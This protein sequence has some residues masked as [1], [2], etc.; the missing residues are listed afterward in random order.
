[1]HTEQP[2]LVRA[3]SVKEEQA[4]AN[5]AYQEADQEW[6][7]SDFRHIFA[8]SAEGFAPIADLER[9]APVEQT[10]L[11]NTRAC[12]KRK[13]DPKDS[14][15]KNAKKAQLE[16]NVAD[17]AAMQDRCAKD[18]LFQLTRDQLHEFLSSVGKKV[19][20][21]K[22]FLIGRI[23][24][25]FADSDGRAHAPAAAVDAV[26]LA[27]ETVSFGGAEHV[28]AYIIASI[29]KKKGTEKHHFPY[30]LPS[31]IFVLEDASFFGC[32]LLCGQCVHGSDRTPLG[33]SRRLPLP[34][35]MPL[36]H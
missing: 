22:A 7:V 25:H 31:L 11:T 20:G 26:L 36:H 23:Q 1:M 30:V 18:K 5:A 4:E 35:F 24:M 13:R 28:F 15:T 21:K 34:T 12:S 32:H 27:R 2:L 14:V 29:N 17:C 10:G 19:G 3:F 9:T 8:S 16:F 6:C 33:G